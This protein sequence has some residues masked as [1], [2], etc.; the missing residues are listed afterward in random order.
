[1]NVS[2]NLTIKDFQNIIRWQE[3][4]T[5]SCEDMQRADHD[6]KIKIEAIM[7]TIKE[8]FEKDREIC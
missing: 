3:I 2:L 6:T 4:A 1:M 7:I 5:K 8:S